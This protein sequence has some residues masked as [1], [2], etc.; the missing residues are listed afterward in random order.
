MYVP[1]FPCPCQIEASNFVSCAACIGHS[2]DR[3]VNIE[4]DR[5]D[6]GICHVQSGS[7]PTSSLQIHHVESDSSTI[8]STICRGNK[9]HLITCRNLEQPKYITVICRLL[10]TK[11][12]I[13][14]I[15]F[16]ETSL[17]HVHVKP[18]FQYYTCRCVLCMS[19]NT[20]CCNNII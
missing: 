18:I 11:I 3:A 10:K 14:S 2:G 7:F 4:L 15:C 16:V 5:N 12:E 1:Q 17:D 8:R 6:L 19:N 20:K 13:S 9:A